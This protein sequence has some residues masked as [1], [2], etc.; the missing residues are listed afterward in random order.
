MVEECPEIKQNP[1]SINKLFIQFIDM[2]SS[3]NV[4]KIFSEYAFVDRVIEFVFWDLLIKNKSNISYK[5]LNKVS[6][7]EFL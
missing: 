1:K 3:M 2:L 4:E 7:E 6:F 5:N